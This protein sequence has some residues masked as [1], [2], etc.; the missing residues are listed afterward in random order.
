MK[1]RSLALTF[2]IDTIK[3]PAAKIRISFDFR[4]RELKITSYTSKYGLKFWDE[5]SKIHST[6]Q[7]HA[8]I[9][10]HQNHL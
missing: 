9:A 5:F 1:I 4:Y 10:A 7:K 3:T 8:Q 2:D 6:A